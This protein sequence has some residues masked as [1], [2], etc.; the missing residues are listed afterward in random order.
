MLKDHTDV[1]TTQEAAE[2]LG[3][4]VTSVQKLVEGGEMPAWKT[5][6]GHRRIPRE[7]VLAFKASGTVPRHDKGAPTRSTLLVVEDEEMQRAVFATQ[8]AK[9]NLPLDVTF[10]KNGYEALIEIGLRAPDILF[11]DI[12]MRG[13]DGYE[14]M[15]TVLNRPSL[16]DVNIAI[17]SGVLSEEL[18]ARGGVPPGVAFFPK[19]VRYD[20]LRG[21]ATACCMRK[22]RLYA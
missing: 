15:E 22:Q 21:F 14:V 18:A 10:C 13:L 8:F 3:L 17:V 6:G 2:I 16:R 20:E 9:W 1:C 11:L 5:P 7:S 12:S 19:P 4:S